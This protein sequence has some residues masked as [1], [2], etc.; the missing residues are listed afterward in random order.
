MEATDSSS[1]SML[2]A[3]SGGLPNGASSHF[4]IL[5]NEMFG[6]SS[7]QE[8]NDLLGH[9]SSVNKE[10]C[11]YFY[12]CRDEP[13]CGIE[14][15]FLARPYIAKCKV[16]QRRLRISILRALV[17]KREDG[18]LVCLSVGSS[19]DWEPCDLFQ[20]AVFADN[21]YRDA[22]FL[23]LTDGHIDRSILEAS[24]SQKNTKNNIK[25]LNRVY[26]ANLREVENV[27]SN[28]Y[29]MIGTVDLDATEED[30]QAVV[31]FLS[32]FLPEKWPNLLTLLGWAITG[33]TVGLQK[34]VV[35]IGSG[36]NGKGLL[37]QSIAKA[38]PNSTITV[39]P[40]LLDRSS[41]SSKEGPTSFLKTA[42]SHPI[43]V[44]E[45]VPARIDENLL[46][47]MSGGGTISTRGLYE[48]NF[49]QTQM[50]SLLM[51]LTNN[52]PQLGMSDAIKRRMLPVFCYADFTRFS[53]EH[54]A[55]I[56]KRSAAWCRLIL[57][58]SQKE[59]DLT[60][61]EN[62]DFDEYDAVLDQINGILR[63]E[64]GKGVRV[65][66]V[67]RRLSSSLSAFQ[68]ISKLKALKYEVTEF[69]GKKRRDAL[70]NNVRFKTNAELLL[71]ESEADGETVVP[72]SSS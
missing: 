49:T 51:L 69:P 5:V 11:D 58:H 30:I 52:I 42:V 23:A 26:D 21:L 38:F 35:L 28:R 62:Y 6:F 4:H 27:P 10:P 59:L 64:R 24:V 50:R 2:S 34:F 31:D 15:L 40:I 44:V 39:P 65:K 43:V 7:L 37:S 48:K 72:P 22:R 67:Q 3:G 1:L 25:T 56:V 13:S 9:S 32:E 46:K 68:V 19:F 47:L 18:V 53:N 71:E 45:E 16:C 20:T 29:T 33:R 61:F 8:L 60:P 70:V 41:S 12:A 66:A 57:E 36:G 14:R 54:N 55:G 17:R 63:P